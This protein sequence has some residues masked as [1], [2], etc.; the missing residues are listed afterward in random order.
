MA[1]RGEDIQPNTISSITGTVAF[2]TE[3]E[4]HNQGQFWY[5]WLKPVGKYINYSEP[6]I[7]LVVDESN[8]A[9][10]MLKIAAESNSNQEFEMS[11]QI[12]PKQTDY[13]YFIISKDEEVKQISSGV[14]T[15]Q[16]SAPIDTQSSIQIRQQIINSAPIF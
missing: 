2:W 5:F 15:I 8:P 4:P 1:S 9:I 12:M 3:A 14:P 10:E 6:S 16:A 7:C 11:V 13:L